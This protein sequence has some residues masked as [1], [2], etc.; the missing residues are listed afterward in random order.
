MSIDVY[1][2][3][4]KLGYLLQQFLQFSTGLLIKLLDMIQP[5]FLCLTALKSIIGLRQTAK[6]MKEKEYKVA[7]A[8]CLVAFPLGFIIIGHGVMSFLH[9][10]PSC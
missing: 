1:V 2:S 8:K 10:I 6:K 9:S 7:D 3:T 4:A 5:N